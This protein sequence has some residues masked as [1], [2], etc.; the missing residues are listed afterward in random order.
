MTKDELVHAIYTM[1]PSYR[2]LKIDLYQYSEAQLQLAYDRKKNK[3]VARTGGWYSNYTPAVSRP[4]PARTDGFEEVE[5]TETTTTRRVVEKKSVSLT[6][7]DAL[8]KE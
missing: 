5:Y 3:P 6:G 1:D 2:K 7:F 4:R 8:R